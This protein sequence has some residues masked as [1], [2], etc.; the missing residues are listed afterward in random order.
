MSEGQPVL[1]PE[2]CDAVVADP[3][4]LNFDAIQSETKTFQNSFQ[5]PDFKGLPKK[6]EAL[7]YA[8][9]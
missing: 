4:K 7:V 9:G 5:D 3:R 1:Q 6:Q 2:D 8:P